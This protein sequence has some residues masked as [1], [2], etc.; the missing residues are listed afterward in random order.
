MITMLSPW[1]DAVVGFGSA[2]LLIAAAQLLARV[3]ETQGQGGPGA[4][5]PG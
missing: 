2:F 4:G 3:V 5:R 1:A